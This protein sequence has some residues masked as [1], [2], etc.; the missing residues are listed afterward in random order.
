[1]F[2]FF[3]PFFLLLGSLSS[4]WVLLAFAMQRPTA[5][6][7]E[8]YQLLWD[9]IAS[10]KQC[11][12]AMQHAFIPVRKCFLILMKDYFIFLLSYFYIAIN[13]WQVFMHLRSSIFS[14]DPWSKYMPGFCFSKIWILNIAKYSTLR[15]RVFSD[16]RTLIVMKIVISLSNATKKV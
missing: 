1:M 10:L 5:S 16:P 4:V 13:I 2:F 12:Q 11:E 14:V 6:R 15:V 3:S 7:T 9:T 8:N